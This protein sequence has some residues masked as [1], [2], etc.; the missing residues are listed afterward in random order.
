MGT[1][2]ARRLEVDKAQC[3]GAIIYTV[4]AFIHAVYDAAA[5]LPDCGVGGKP[6]DCAADILGVLSAVFD[7]SAEISSATTSCGTGGGACSSSVNG[8]LQATTDFSADLIAA[9]TT[10]KAA[11]DAPWMCTFDVI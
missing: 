6:E 3:A 5:G 4:Q 9:A 8:A 7:M 2:T 11:A 10:C 1:A